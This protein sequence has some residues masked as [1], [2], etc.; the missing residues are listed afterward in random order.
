MKMLHSLS[1]STSNKL[2]RK[3]QKSIM[4]E[5]SQN[6]VYSLLFGDL[7]HKSLSH[8][9]MLQCLRTTHSAQVVDKNKGKK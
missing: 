9:S 2:D 7:C 8:L 4:N 6:L 3:N 1:K 5:K